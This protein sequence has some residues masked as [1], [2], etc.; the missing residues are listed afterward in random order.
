MELEAH[1]AMDKM[2]RGLHG[3]PAISRTSSG[4]YD[5]EREHPESKVNRL[6]YLYPIKASRYCC[7]VVQSLIQHSSVQSLQSCK[8]R[9]KHPIILA[10]Q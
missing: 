10:F 3:S 4:I 5:A 9:L 6:F 1:A 7:C 8:L 2:G